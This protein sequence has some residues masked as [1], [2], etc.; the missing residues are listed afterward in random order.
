MQRCKIN[1]LIFGQCIDMLK[2]IGYGKS[3]MMNKYGLIK[4]FKM[5]LMKVNRNKKPENT[6]YSIFMLENRDFV[7]S[8]NF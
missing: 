1:R 6:K 2:Y 7:L 3:K 8:I 5:D 4:K